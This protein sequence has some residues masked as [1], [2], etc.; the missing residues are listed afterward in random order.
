MKSKLYLFEH[1]VPGWVETARDEYVV[2]LR[3]FA[4]FE[5]CPLKTPSQERESADVKRRK[6]ADVL[7]QQMDLKDLVVLFDEGGKTF[8]SSENFADQLRRLLE[9]GK[10]QL[11]F[12]IGGPYGFDP[13]V[14]A[15]SQ[16]QWSLS[17]LTFNHWLAQLVALEQI[18]RGWTILKGLPYHNR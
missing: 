3:G 16:A 5:I 7:L 10:Q 6:E 9:S 17:G 13:R 14:K 15:R 18:Y 2:K 11:V 1:K 12:C 4:P 8:T